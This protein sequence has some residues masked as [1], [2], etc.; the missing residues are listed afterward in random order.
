MYKQAGTEG[1]SQGKVSIIVISLLIFLMLTRFS[2]VAATHYVDCAVPSSG[3]GQS[4]ATAWKALSNITGLSAGDTVYISGSSSCSSY[5]AT[6]WTPINGTVATPII[7]S[8]GQD[9]GHNSAVTITLSGSPGLTGT[10]NLLQGIVITGLSNGTINMSINGLLGAAGS[11]AWNGVRLSYLNMNNTVIEG[12]TFQNFQLDHCAATVPAGTDHFF[13][14]GASAGSIGYTSNTIDDNLIELYQVN[15]GSGHGT[16]GF[17]WIENVSFFSNVMVMLFNSTANSQHADGIQTSGSYVAIYDNYFEN[18]GNYP[19]YGDLFGN[20]AHWRVY[21]NV[22]TEFSGHG[23]NISAYGIGIGFEV[24]NCCTM[25]DFTVANNTIDFANGL[26]CIG[27]NPGNT[28]NKAT[29]S[30]IVNNICYN[31]GIVSVPG[32][33]GSIIVSHNAQ[34]TSGLT[35]VNTGPYPTG[36]WHLTSGATAAIGQGIMPAPSYLTSFFTTDKDGNPR[37]DP[38]DLGA[39]K[40]GSS[41]PPPPPIGLTAT[42]Q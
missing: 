32:N 13:T 41:D 2:A 36:D 4:W 30:Y 12:T 11:V 10:S 42:T 19:V 39:Y 20:T 23:T 28:G 15:D 29:N 14:S 7:Y 40:Y 1:K 17:Q 35:F 37:T 21:N 25:D 31:T 38:W 5:S 16:D 24:S 6:Q 3:N 18:F 27:I 22:L 26:N 34:G 8:V 9:A 33:G